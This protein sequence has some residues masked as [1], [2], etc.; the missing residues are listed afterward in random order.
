[1]T[2]PGGLPSLMQG[3]ADAA[4]A[5]GRLT[6]VHGIAGQVTGV[7]AGLPLEGCRLIVGRL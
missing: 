2:R 4:E 3:M 1:L 6:W 7:A 5:L